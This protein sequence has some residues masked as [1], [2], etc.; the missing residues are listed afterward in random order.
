MNEGKRKKILEK[1]VI[2]PEEMKKIEKRKEKV[3]LY[4]YFRDR[5]LTYWND[6]F[7]NAGL[8]KMFFGSAKEEEILAVFEETAKPE[9]VKQALIYLK[10]EGLIE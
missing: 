9:E 7:Q 3:L 6:R 5:I 2:S 10:N 4:F 8:P 1:L